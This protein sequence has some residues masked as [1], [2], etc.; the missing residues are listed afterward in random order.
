[1]NSKC[2]KTNKKPTKQPLILLLYQ[3]LKSVNLIIVLFWLVF[4]QF[5]LDVKASK[6]HDFIYRISQVRIVK[7]YQNGMM[8]VYTNFKE[9]EFVSYYLKINDLFWLFSFLYKKKGKNV[10]YMF[11]IMYV[12]V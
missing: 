2:E 9:D 3:L 4:L 12:S 7:N 8:I 10:T 6:I 1:M 5:L 11:C